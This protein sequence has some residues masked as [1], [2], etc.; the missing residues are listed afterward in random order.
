[1]TVQLRDIS[2]FICTD[3]KY[4][5]PVRE[6]GYPLSAPPRGRRVLLATNE[7]YQVSDYDFTKINMI[8]TVI[9]L[10]NIPEKVKDSWFRGKPYILLKITVILPST[11]LQN[12]R[13]V[14]DALIKHHASKEAV[15]PVLFMYTDGGPEHRTNFLSEKIA[16]IAL[17][18]FIDLDQIIVAR[19]APG[20]SFTNL[21]ERI[22]CILNLGFYRIRYMRQRSSNAEFESKI[23]KCDTLSKQR[24][25]VE[26]NSENEAL[27]VHLVLIL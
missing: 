7:S 1:M 15:P 24:N 4:K 26:K 21:A 20:H 27:R 18:K 5:V 16:I 22:N 12:A 2:N 10:N 19:T 14:A 17:Q 6:P 13:Q 8:P 9:L 3:D 25:L 11:S 23:A